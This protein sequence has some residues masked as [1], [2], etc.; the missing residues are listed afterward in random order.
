M[1]SED[2]NPPVSVVPWDSEIRFWSRVADFM[3]ELQSEM[4]KIGWEMSP[5][6]A[7]AL[8]AWVVEWCQVNHVPGAGNPAWVYVFEKLKERSIELQGTGQNAMLTRDMPEWRDRGKPSSSEVLLGFD[9]FVALFRRALNVLRHEYSDDDV[10]ASGHRLTL[11]E[12]VNVLFI[13]VDWCS[14]FPHFQYQTPYGWS[15]SMPWLEFVRE[16]LKVWRDDLADQSAESPPASGD[17]AFS[18]PRR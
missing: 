13:G 16:E 14:K 4:N 10:T 18:V 17:T 7:Y 9:W 11:G 1:I 12:A 2:S 5:A 3:A 6:N 15:V 8:L